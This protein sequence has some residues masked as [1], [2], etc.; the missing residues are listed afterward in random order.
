MVRLDTEKEP[1]LPRMA[2]QPPQFKLRTLLLAMAAICGLLTV[3]VAIG[4]A[5]ALGLL[6]LVLLVGAH[7][8]GNAIGTQL[9]DGT[10][11]SPGTTATAVDP[12]SVLSTAQI[13]A[14]TEWKSIKTSRMQEKLPISWMFLLL[15]AAG[16]I[17]GG[18]FGGLLVFSLYGEQ[19]SWVSASIAIIA[20]G[21]IG[22]IA[23]FVIGTFIDMAR[24][25]WSDAARD[26]SPFKNGS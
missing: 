19:L 13:S 8:A 23:T 21:I 11:Q 18:I 7:V 17:A 10:D 2:L 22:G 4:M 5:W 9:R 6:M 1:E 15:A 16:A 25:V 3:M 14:A 26:Q 12:F 24:R 20:L